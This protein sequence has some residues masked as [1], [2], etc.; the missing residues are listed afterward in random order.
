[1]NVA[2][3]DAVIAIWNAKNFYDRGGRSPR[4]S[5]P[6]RTATSTRHPSPLGLPLVVTPV[7][8]EYPSGHSAVSNAGATTLAL[9]YG[10]QTSFSVTSFGLPGVEHTF[11]SFSSG[12]A[13]VARCACV[14]GHPLPLRL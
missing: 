6:G 7:Y 14:R 13:E 1:M 10:D 3:T 4:S 9:F 2:L 8:Q 11:A 12:A 5:R